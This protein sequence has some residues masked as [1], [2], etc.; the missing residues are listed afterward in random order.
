MKLRKKQIKVPINF[1]IPPW[2]IPIFQRGNFDF[3]GGVVS[4]SS[5]CV[6]VP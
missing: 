5:A 1:F 6:G 3:L 4:E 2:G